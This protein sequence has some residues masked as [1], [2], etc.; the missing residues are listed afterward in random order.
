MG[1]TVSGGATPGSGSGLGKKKVTKP[2]CVD[3]AQFKV[4]WSA[5]LLTE[6]TMAYL[7]IAVSFAPVTGD[8][9][10]MTKDLVQLFNITTLKLILGSGAIKTPA[11]LR[12]I[13]AKHLAITAQSLGLLLSLLPHIRA[14]LLAQLPPNRHMQLLELDRVS[15]ELLDHHGQLLAKFVVILG[16]A[17]DASAGRLSSVDW[18]RSH[19]KAQVGQNGQ[20]AGPGDYFDDVIR[21]VS[22]LHRVLQDETMLPPEQVQDVFSR[23]FSLLARRIP[24]HFD[25]VM[26]VTQ[27]GRQR[28]LDEVSHL[29]S[30]LALL[31]RV[32][33]SPAMATLEEAFSKRYSK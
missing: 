7:D 12:S 2:A 19:E 1:V 28:I 8:I 25:D 15:H 24:Q 21:N 26:P 4:V 11:Q 13:S 18:D 20:S 22:A 6:I 5:M 14:A 29:V 16:D 27:T 17:V 32:D 33:S 9:I 31:P 3:G 23:I 10:S 30:A